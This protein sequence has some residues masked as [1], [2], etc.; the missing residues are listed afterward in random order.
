MKKITNI[1]EHAGSGLN[2][3][4]STARK[5]DELSKGLP[6]DFNFRRIAKTPTSHQLDA[7]ERTDIST[8][9]TDAVDR[10]G[11][12]VIP[13][14]GDWKDYNRVVTFAHRYDQLPAGSN[15]W[16]KPK[17]NGL[18]AKTHYPTKPADWGDAAWLP[19]AVLHLMQQPV[20]TCTGKS[21]GFLPLNVRAATPSEKAMR[22]E[23]D[24][25]PIIDKWAGLE[26]AVAPLPCNA[27]AEMEAVSKGIKSG[28]FDQDFA[29]MVQKISG[30][31]AMKSTNFI[32]HLRVIAEH[33]P[34]MLEGIGRM[35]GLTV[36]LTVSA[37]KFLMTKGLVDEVDGGFIAT[38][39]GW[40]TLA[41]AATPVASQS[42]SF[43]PACKPVKGAQAFKGISFAPSEPT[44]QL[45]RTYS[46][47]VE[48]GDTFEP[49]GDINLE[50][51]LDKFAYRIVNTWSG[52]GFSKMLPQTDDLY[53]FENSS[54]QTVLEEIDNFWKLKPDYEKLGLMH[55]RGIMLYGP[56]G[57]GKTCIMHQV[58]K[59]IVDRGDVVF[60]AKRIGTLIDGL[61]AFR[62]IEPDRKVVVAL[63]DADEYAGGEEREFLQ[64]LDGETSVNGVL[65]LAS[66]NYI[67]RFPPRLLRSGR[68]D[69]KVF[70]PFPPL[71]GR[72]A[73]LSKKLNGLEKQVEIDRL[74]TATD[75]L[76]FGDL[77]ELVTAVYVLKE[78]VDTV[79]A[80]LKGIAATRRSK[81]MTESTS[82]TGGAVVPDSP[83]MPKCTKCGTNENVEA[84]KGEAGNYFQCKTC[85][86]RMKDMDDDT[87]TD[88]VKPGEAA[89][90]A[91]H[92]THGDGAPSLNTTAVDHAKTLIGDGKVDDGEWSISAEDENAILGE[93]GD[94]W[95]AY[96]KWFL[97]EDRNAA[98]HTKDRYKYP[99]GK[100]GKVYVRALNAIRSRASQQGA[101]AIHGAAGE[102]L[103]K[104]KAPKEES[105]PQSKLAKTIVPD[106]PNDPDGDKDPVAICPMCREKVEQGESVEVSGLGAFDS[107]TCPRCGNR[108]LQQ[109]AARRDPETSGNTD[110]T[111]DQNAGTP[112]A[113]A[114][115]SFIRPE[116]LARAIE[117]KRIENRKRLAEKIA[118]IVVE[119]VEKRLGRV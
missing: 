71:A 113:A 116:T 92:M 43:V 82:A 90:K 37:V 18:I 108:L 59:M 52:V 58:A 35:L 86:E 117:L 20:P 93:G 45:A 60:Y 118:P 96:S 7:G 66:T 5:I 25:V 6:K 76:S 55:N 34:V 2:M 41:A 61:K 53:Y 31:Y 70:V 100:G 1:V 39:M 79:L 112:A 74:A 114:A 105:E 24:R 99:F 62:E 67:D 69:K 46:Q 77:K 97:G 83:V 30:Y 48:S 40:Q 109:E 73:Y 17:A 103:D 10:D 50:K 42:K 81:S 75:G 80:R 68:F 27:Q 29:D 28:V 85:G 21:I 14:G 111:P 4:E 33:G 65:Y 102:L 110:G 64:L 78:P 38:E 12:C 3:P 57:T 106:G 13:S 98:E 107:F 22:P 56:P 72:T 87:D 51:T 115:K 16:I 47:Y 104:I 9:T 11:E 84:M 89:T 8:I 95:P 91:G 19:S 94:D 54:M 63:E 26:Y 101:T 15:W 36:P 32:P 88:S 23:L 49:V 44:M 119:V